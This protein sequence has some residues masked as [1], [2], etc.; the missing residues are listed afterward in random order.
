MGGDHCGKGR[1][2]EELAPMSAALVG[3]SGFL[4]CF[5]GF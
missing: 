3:G 5:G 2:A 1:T 4:G